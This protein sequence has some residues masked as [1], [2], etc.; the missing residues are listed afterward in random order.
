MVKK[1]LFPGQLESEKVVIYE[2]RHW[3]A[4]IKWIGVR[5]PILLLVS[6]MIAWGATKLLAPPQGIKL[7]YWLSILAPAL[8]WIV[9]RVLDWGND[10]YIVTN[11]RVIHRERVY[12]FSEER[13]EAYLDRVQDVTIEIINPFAN[14]LNFGDVI[15]ET[16]SKAGTIEFQAISKPRDIQ[17]LL[18]ESAGLPPKKG[19]LASQPQRRLLGRGIWRMFYPTY[20]S[21]EEDVIIWRKHWWVL[22]RDLVL[23]LLAIFALGTIWLWALTSLKYPGWIN[24]LFTLGLATIAFWVAFKLIDWH[25]DLY[26]LTKDRVIDIEKKPFVFEHRREANLDAIQDVSLE[27]IGL[28]AKVLDF[29]NV[30]LKTA[31][32]AGE[33]TFD[34]VPHPEE[35][36]ATIAERLNEFRQEKRLADQERQRAAIVAIVEDHLR[37]RE[38]DER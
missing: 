16:A 23:P 31:S 25:N 20:P 12:F 29:G 34:S 24:V 15:I 17:R 11:K 33:F 21:E 36:Q 30:L 6:L 14:V 3:F 5:P 28:T 2:R 27:Q 13:K 18:L 7:V 10:R 26:I 8:I 9:W 4:I 35:V 37:Q 32:G 1:P 38:T 19:E 22:N